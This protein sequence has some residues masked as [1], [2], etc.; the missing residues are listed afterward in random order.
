MKNALCALAVFSA[1][2]GLAAPASAVFVFTV[3]ST[4]DQ[5]DLDVF[6]GVCQTAA[7]SCT[8][9]A[10]VMQ[11]NRIPAP[12]ATI[13]LPA[14]VYFLT[15]LP[16]GANGDDSGDLNLSSPLSGSPVIA[17][18]GA[19][20]ANTIIDGNQIDHVFTVEMDRTAT[21]SGVTIRRGHIVGGLGLGGSGGGI[22]NWGNLTL[23]LAIVSGNS[24]EVVGGGLSNYSVASLD[25]TTV[26]GNTAN[27]GGGF[28]NYGT[29]TLDRCT[30]SNNVSQTAG[31]GI[32]NF[33]MGS[34]T[35]TNSTIAFND[36][37]D[38]GGGIYNGYIVNMYNSSIVRNQA[39]SD[40]DL[41]G[42]GG[43]VYINAASVLNMRNS[44]IAG[45]TRSQ[46]PVYTDC[47]GTVVSYGRNKL[48]TTDGCAATQFGAGD[49]GVL[50]SLA[51]LGALQDNGGPTATIGIVA[52]SSMIDGG[53]A[54]LG[55]IGANSVPLAN[56]QRGAPRVAGV[57]CD[58]GAFEYGA[59]TPFFAD[60]FESGDISAWQ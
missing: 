31:G 59:S 19:G 14:G 8:L 37:V 60:G 12:G 7:G 57:R 54:I 48:G 44:V 2:L 35:I 28:A 16:N 25:R 27:L 53:D 56:D 9:R 50:A 15:R 3:N 5:V 26:S 41:G 22:Q 52:P 30:I 42:R 55:C 49:I 23:S 1:L 13:M 45:N 58:I 6:D 33:P 17:I 20:A 18:L 40:G 46:A 10:A 21:I 24:A 32:A 34:L 39:D 47:W 11:A 43:G 4:L 36:A 29:A 51:E 38:H